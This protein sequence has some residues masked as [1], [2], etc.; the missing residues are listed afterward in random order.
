MLTGDVRVKLM[1][2]S[3]KDRK[4]GFIDGFNGSDGESPESSVE[5]RK[6]LFRVGDGARGS[7]RHSGKDFPVMGSQDR[8]FSEAVKDGCR[9]IL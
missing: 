5:G 7:S 4:D 8:L 6:Q 1:E 3:L 9:V 2:I